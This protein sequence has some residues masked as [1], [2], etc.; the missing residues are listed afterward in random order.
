MAHGSSSILKASRSKAG[1]GK[2][3][4]F[5]FVVHKIGS[6]L[7]SACDLVGAHLYKTDNFPISKSL[8]PSY[9]QSS[10]HCSRILY[11]A[12]D[13]AMDL[14]RAAPFIGTKYNQF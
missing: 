6:P 10:F 14:F 13:L 4:Y 2:H 8:L 11:I 7:L 5:L 3:L 1:L 12:I 9:L